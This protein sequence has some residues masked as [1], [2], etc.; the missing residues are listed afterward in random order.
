MKTLIF[1]DKTEVNFTDTSTINDCVAVLNSFDQVDPIANKF[2]EE[3]L[4][5]AIFDN[6]R[7]EN[8]IPTG[9]S[10]TLDGE[11]VVAHFTNTVKSQEAILNEKIEDAQGAIT[12]LAGIVAGLLPVKEEEE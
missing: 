10:A 5:G 3:N 1:K 8:I 2:T 11:K 6:Q 7:V 4:I 9:V 12:E